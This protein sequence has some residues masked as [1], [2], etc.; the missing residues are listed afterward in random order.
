MNTRTYFEEIGALPGEPDAASGSRPHALW[1]MYLSGFILSLVLTFAAYA[2]VAYHA[3]ASVPIL[4]L[5]LVV[6]AFVQFLVQ[7]VFFFHLKIEKAA[8]ERLTV[9]GI[10]VVLV[11]ILVGG[12]IWIIFT[13][14]GRTMPTLEQQIQYVNS[15][16]G[17]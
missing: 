11:A 3:P 15:Q 13:L 7:L 10:S 5:A 9:L 2:L 14:N 4:T 12:S 6:L 16:S 17:I 8:Y 1:P